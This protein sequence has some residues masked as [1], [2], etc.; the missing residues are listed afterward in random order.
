MRTRPTSDTVAVARAIIEAVCAES[1]VSKELLLSR[2][3]E[4]FI[5][6][7]RAAAARQMRNIGM[8]YPEIGWVMGRDHSAIFHLVCPERRAERNLRIKVSK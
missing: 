5:V 8:S 2:R 3:T 6:E 7:V 1:G 4:R